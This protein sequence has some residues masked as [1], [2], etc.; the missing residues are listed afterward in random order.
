MLLCVWIHVYECTHIHVNVCMWK[1][2]TDVEVITI[3]LTKVGSLIE[4]RA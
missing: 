4:L 1:P 2:D 3:L